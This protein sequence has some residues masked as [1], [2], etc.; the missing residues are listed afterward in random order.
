M[1]ALVT[2]TWTRFDVYIRPIDQPVMTPPVQ[3]TVTPSL[4][5][6]PTTM[7]LV[8]VNLVS[9]HAFGAFLAVLYLSVELVI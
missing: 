9:F 7:P 1:N 3:P 8:F 4:V 6:A 5:P 2:Y